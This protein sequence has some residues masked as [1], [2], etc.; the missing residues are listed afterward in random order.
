MKL[1]KYLLLFCT[2]L[3]VLAACKETGSGFSIT[4]TSSDKYTVET[5]T[6]AV[7]GES[8]TVKVTAASEDIIVSSV[9]FNSEEATLKSSE[10][11]VTTW[12]FVMPASNVLLEITADRNPSFPITWNECDSYTVEAP[13]EARAN[14]EVSVTVTPAEGVVINGLMYNDNGCTLVSSEG[15]KS[16]FSFTMPAQAVALTVDYT[17]PAKTYTITAKNDDGVY[18]FSVA[19]SAEE[20]SL[21][22]FTM[23]F[24]NQTYKVTSVSFGNEET[25]TL[26]GETVED[27]FTTYEFEFTMPS[28]NV[29]LTPAVEKNWHRIYRVSSEHAEVKALNCLVKDEHGNPIPDEDG[30]WICQ[31]VKGQMFH[32]MVYPEMGYNY[33]ITVKGESGKGYGYGPATAPDF[34][35]CLG[36][37]MPNEPITV[38]ATS[39]EKGDYLGEPFVGTYSGCFIDILEASRIS[40]SASAN[41]VAELKSNTVF[42]VRTTDVNAFDFNGTYTYDK[43]AG[44]FRYNHAD[45]KTYGLSGKTEDAFNLFIVNNKLEDMPEHTRFYIV[46]K[47]ESSD[48][49]CASN[50]SKNEALIQIRNSAG[51]N[52]FYLFTRSSYSISPVEVTFESGSSIADAGAVAYFTDEASGTS[53][54][55]S[56]EGGIAV[57]TKGGQEA[58]AYAPAE[59]GEADLV[60]DGFGKGTYKGE[61]GTYTVDGTIVE[62]T[63]ASGTKSFILDFTNRTYT[64][65]G[66]EGGWNGPVEYYVEGEFGM[67]NGKVRK[68]SISIKLNVEESKADFIV[69]IGNDYNELNT[70]DIYSVSGFTYDSEAGTITISQVYV[71]TGVGW[72]AGRQDFVLN[73]S[74]DK[75][76]LTFKDV[77][78]IYSPASNSRYV[79]VT[80]LAIPAI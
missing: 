65:V 8:I 1:L 58:G 44:S 22:K 28:R 9:K 68:A 55:Y 46:S 13:A 26:L 31:Q 7:P 50:A 16:V 19:K 33:E 75:S 30:N 74:A 43:S 67:N 2:A 41:A 45:C 15:G 72:G 23:T 25:C 29:T 80:D 21:V 38:E 53:Y 14:E 51:N 6:E 18:S 60:L 69:R 64:I 34:G 35:A 63:A 39:S 77:D 52:V 10:G 11:T 47:E 40:S 5:V 54:R 57:F 42:T 59:G 27:E 32:F 70:T 71:G 62:F 78:N 4:W 73:V 66:G 76:E 20:G 37:Q 12:N 79:I 24:V 36:I 61:E 56:V 3:T 48:Y 49:V 17:A